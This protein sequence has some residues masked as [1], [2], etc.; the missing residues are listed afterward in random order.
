MIMIYNHQ[1]RIASIKV[2]LVLDFLG[3]SSGLG[4]DPYILDPYPETMCLFLDCLVFVLI[5][6]EYFL[7]IGNISD[8]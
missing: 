3:K 4:T 1:I 2:L 5:Y 8:A 7:I 6:E